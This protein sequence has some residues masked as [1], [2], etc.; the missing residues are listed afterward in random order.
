MS[1]CMVLSLVLLLAGVATADDRETA[2]RLEA[3]GVKV[4]LDASGN[5]TE[6]YCNACQELKPEHY[7]LIGSLSG[8]KVLTLYKCPMTDDTLALLANLPNLERVG[9]EGAKFT[10]VGLK[11]MAGWK[12]LKQMTFFHILHDGFNGS[13]AK[14]LAGLQ[15][16]E[17]FG[18][19]GSTFT[20]AGME[21][22]GE[23][24]HLKSV[25]FWHC[26]NTD[27]GTVHLKKLPELRAVWLAPQFT[28]RITDKSLEILATIPT[29]EEVKL[30][31]TR[32]SWTSLQKLNNLPKLKKVILDETD[33]TAD[34]LA[35]LVAALP[36]VAI[37]RK[38]PT[39]Q[40][41]QWFE[42]RFP[43]RR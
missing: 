22:V 43:P 20:D 14:H 4:K 25:R 18:C 13:G 38:P 33:I 30:T 37:T 34:D 10:D 27:A 19:G 42:K 17:N 40:Q 16:L 9:I 7:Q 11:Q 15:H 8:I 23:L 31:E 39:E 41:Q 29:L 21:A 3:V 26:R 2:K 32:L 5:A 28:P 12:N 6:V 36:G 1:R 35:K 24:K